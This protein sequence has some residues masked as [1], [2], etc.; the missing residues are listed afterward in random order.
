MSQRPKRMRW[1]VFMIGTGL[2]VGVAAGS[3]APTAVGAASDPERQTQTTDKTTVNDTEFG[4]SGVVIEPLTTADLKQLE[5]GTVEAA[6]KDKEEQAVTEAAGGNISVDFRDADIH[7]VLRILAF[8]GGVNVVSGKE[9]EGLVTI[10][11]TDVP[12][13]TALDVI[14]KTYGFAYDRKENII[15]VT[16]V[17]N[18]AQEEV[19]TELFALSYAKAKDVKASVEKMLTDRGTLQVDDRTN[20]VVATDIPTN[21]FKISQVIKRLDQPTAQVY[22][23]ARIVETKL[24]GNENLG[25]NWSDSFS[26]GWNSST[27]NAGTSS[28]AATTFSAPTTFPFT[29]TGTFGEL[30]NSLIRTPLPDPGAATL[31]TLSF[32]DLKLTLDMLS[33]RDNTHIIS[34]PTIVVLDNQEAV[35]KIVD[36]EPDFDFSLDQDTGNVTVS[37]IKKRE[38]GTILKVTPHVNPTGEIVVDIEPEVSSRTGARS[39]TIGST[40]TI[41]VPIFAKQTAK[42][43]VRIASGETIAIGGLVKD[44]TNDVDE[45]IPFLKDIPVIGGLFGTHQ[46]T[47]TEKRDLVIFLTV[48]VKDSKAL[49]QEAAA[50]QQKLAGAQSK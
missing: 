48:S 49:A 36:E 7:N 18:L 3:V 44:S 41:P 1:L 8:K 38:V 42:T 4:G 16:T 19:N 28:T 37:G 26:M 24:S 13:E 10:K 50:R 5:T 21:L 6:D 34:N 27:T 11:L 29:K 31:G 40:T 15:R 22:I 33:K 43:Q 25:I 12:W 23:E 17:G 9:V 2:A 39:V 35:V 45:G 47:I 20:T 32:T 46:K 30:G 14:L